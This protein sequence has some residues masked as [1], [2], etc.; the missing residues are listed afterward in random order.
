MK[1]AVF[2]IL[3]IL[4]GSA[5]SVMGQPIK[6]T[7]ILEIHGTIRAKYEYEPTVGKG[8]FEIRNARMSVEGKVIPIVRYKAEID[9]SDEGQI[10][11]L[12]AYVR[13]Q[14]KER[15]KFTFG[16]VRV[17]FSTYGSLRMAV[18]PRSR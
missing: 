18:S 11:M 6:N 15:L 14:P 1:K 4:A 13:L 2:V 16:R 5:V 17:P 12:D 3:G 9:L 10:K 7:Y 8:R